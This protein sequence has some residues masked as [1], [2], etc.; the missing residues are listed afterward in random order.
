MFCKVE[1]IMKNSERFENYMTTMTN[2]LNSGKSFKSS[3]KVTADL[4][5]IWMP[6]G[7][8]SASGKV[9]HGR[10]FKKEAFRDS[11]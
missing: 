6:K 4:T 8:K 5:F 10:S 9:I 3:S 7:G 2:K 1:E 11:D